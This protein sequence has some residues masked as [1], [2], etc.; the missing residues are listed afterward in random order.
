MYVSVSASVVCICVID[1]DRLVVKLLLLLFLRLK[2]TDPDR[3]V[4][5]LLLFLRL[6]NRLS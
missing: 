4:V 6:K 3:L 1:P 2:I 5:M